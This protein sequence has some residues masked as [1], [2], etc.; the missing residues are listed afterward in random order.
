MVT[1]KKPALQGIAFYVLIDEI[2]LIRAEADK[3]AGV[4]AEAHSD[5]TKKQHQR[6]SRIEDIQNFLEKALEQ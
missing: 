5:N 2:V 1:V 3:G 6:L 4:S